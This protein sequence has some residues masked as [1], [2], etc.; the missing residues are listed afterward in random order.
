MMNGEA[1]GAR[2]SRPAVL[3]VEDDENL[4]VALADNLEHEGI[5]V[6]TAASGREAETLLGT[7]HVD[8]VV[9]DIM[10]P[11]A[12]GYTLCQRIRR[13]PRPP[14]LLMLTARTHED[15]VVR[16]FDVGADDYLAKPY[17]LRELLARVRAL[18]R[19]GE[20]APETLALGELT[21][22]VG[23]RA[24]RDPQGGE[25]DLTK[26]EFDLLWMLLRHAGE[27]LDRDTILDE[28]RGRSVMVDPRTIDNF[29]SSLKKKLDWTPES[30][31]RIATV[32]GVGYRLER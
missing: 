22:D 19:R 8:L 15:D 26:T 2:A 27:A 17:R 25:I 6:S 1:N 9:L 16:G 24:V 30:P 3:I 28:L 20:P 31:W 32:R 4:R 18:L 7:T 10:L 11:D 29:V 21:I 5:Q 12:D 14:R 13:D 23:G